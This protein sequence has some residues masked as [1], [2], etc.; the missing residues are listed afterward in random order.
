MVT[1]SLTWKTKKPLLNLL[2]IFLGCLTFFLFFF[3]LT[4]K[5]NIQVICKVSIM[6]IQWLCFKKY[7]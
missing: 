4:N 3:F 1:K 5:I 2:L 6:Q 7:T